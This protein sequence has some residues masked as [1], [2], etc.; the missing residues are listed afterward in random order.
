MPSKDIYSYSKIGHPWNYKL[1]N[2]LQYLLFLDIADT[3]KS[4]IGKRAWLAA[5]VYIY[6]FTNL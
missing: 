6:L 3:E 4:I 2:S 5:I 1:Y